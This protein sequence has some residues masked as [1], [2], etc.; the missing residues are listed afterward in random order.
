MLLL[1]A[2]YSGQSDVVLG[3]TVAGRLS[4][5]AGVES[6]VGL[7]INTLPLRAAVDEEEALVLRLRGVQDQLV[8]M[9]R[10]EAS[11]PLKVHEWSDVP[12]GRPLFESIVI[13][14]NTP[15]DPGLLGR[16]P[17]G[18]EDARIYDQTSYPITVVA[19]PG[20]RLTPPDRLRR[21]AVR[22]GVGGPDA[23][24]FP[25][26]PGG[27]RRGTRSPDRGAVDAS[28]RPSRSRCSGRWARSGP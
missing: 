27:D 17:L 23:R 26:A 4:D 18:I 1:L 13:V 20:T 24:A 28:R 22:R 15:V 14:Q 3:V 10:F 25:A 5:L 12:R 6:M 19:V 21:E 16:G 2:R 11:P 9:R 7:F 8:E